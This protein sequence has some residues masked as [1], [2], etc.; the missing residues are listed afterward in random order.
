M[1]H[2]ILLA[3]FFLLCNASFAQKVQF[4]DPTNSWAFR[5]TTTGCCIPIR[6]DYATAY[7]DSTGSVSYNGHSYQSL[8][9]AVQ[10][11]LVREDSGRV[12]VIGTSDSIERI[13]YDFNLGLNDTLRMIFPI[14]TLLTWAYMMDS[15][16][17]GGQW[18]KV[19]HFTGFDISI[20]AP[21]SG[22]AIHYNVIEGIGCTNGLY[23]PA[24]PYNLALFSEQMLCFTNNTNILSAL[25]NPIIAFGDTFTSNYD[26]NLSCEE[27]HNHPTA[28][29]VEDAVRQ[30]DP[31]SGG[32]SVVPDPI[33]DASKL[34]FPYIISSGHVAIINSLGQTIY[35]SQFNSSRELNIGDKIKASGMYYYQV[36]DNAGKRTFTGRLI[37]E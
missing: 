37:R 24:S 9:T 23:F 15:T 4:S 35:N 36:M 2:I 26:N 33:N 27:F 12:Y 29:P 19:W 20:Y 22:R 18:Y 17:L 8:V 6:T 21:H 16:Q 30:M 7:Y 5:D 11:V 31:V 10:S 32:V 34:V 3:L 1:K 14:D 13:L 25:S 28:P